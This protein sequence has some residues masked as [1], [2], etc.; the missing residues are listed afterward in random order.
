MPLAPLFSLRARQPSRRS[1]WDQTIL[2]LPDSASRTFKVYFEWQRDLFVNVHNFPAAASP[3][4]QLTKG[5]GE[6]DTLYY[7]PPHYHL[8]ADEYFL[9][10][11]GAGTWHLWD[12]DVRLSAGDKIKVPARSWHWFEGDPS[13]DSPLTTE[14]Y[15]VKGDAVLE[16]RFF[17]NVLGYLA[18]C[19]REE[20]EPSICQLLLFF[21]AFEM[22]PGLR[23]ARWETLN[24]VLNTAIM[25]VGSLI[26]TLMGYRSSYNEYY[27]AQKKN[28]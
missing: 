13:P 3:G 26:G 18:D 11:Q 14:I 16:E 24:L 4:A 6:K 19:H 2:A 7:P 5:D 22:V 28:Q 23:I 9:V 20:V 10:T 1:N 27:Q 15:F 21:R 25:Y 8:F 12:R 17:R